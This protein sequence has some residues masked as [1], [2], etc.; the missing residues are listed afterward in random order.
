MELQNVVLVDGVRSAFARGA[1]G[2]F[3]ATRM[4]DVAV[5]VVEALLAR[6]PEVEKTSIEELGL[7]NV[8]GITEFAGLGANHIARLAGLPETVCTFDTNRQCGSSMETLHRVA[9][10]IMVG[11]IDTGIAL[12]AERMGRNLGGGDEGERNRITEF[13]KKRLELTPLQRNMASDHSEH[14]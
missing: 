14:F 3:V 13:N 4:D 2:S 9:Q 8:T 12:G 7:G 1:R 5:S 6:N 11:A 10:E